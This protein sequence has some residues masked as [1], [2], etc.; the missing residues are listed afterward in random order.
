MAKETV[1][2]ISIIVG[3]LKS[4]FKPQEVGYRHYLP[5][6]TGLLLVTARNPMSIMMKAVW[7]EK[8]GEVRLL[9]HVKTM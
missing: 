1:K 7:V 9:I 8:I 5:W 2:L 4:G 6:G 3:I